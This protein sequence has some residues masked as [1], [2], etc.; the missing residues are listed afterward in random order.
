[1]DGGSAVIRQRFGDGDQAIF[2]F[3]GAAEAI[4]DKFPDDAVK[5]DLPNSHRFGQKIADLADPLGI[6][7][8][9]LVGQGPKKS[10]GLDAPEGRH[11]IFLFDDNNADKVLDAYGEML[12]DTFSERELREG[13]FTAVGQVH[14]PPS[15]EGQPKFPHHMGHYWPNYDPELARRDAAPRVFVQYVLAGQ[16]T[17]ETT[18]EA[19]PAVERIA[20]GVLRLAGMAKGGKSFHHHR[21]IHLHVMNLLHEWAAVRGRYEE[22]IVTYAVKRDVP[23][24]ETWQHYW[25]DVVRTVAET[26]A[27]SSLSGPEVDEFLAWKNRSDDEPALHI[28][29]QRRDNVFRYPN[30][31]PKVHIRIGSIHSIKGETHT[32]TLVCETF[33]NKHNLDKLRPW[34]TGDRKGWKTSDGLQQ[35]Y[36]LKVHY[37]A[38]TRPTH[39]LCLAMKRTTFE[40][41]Q[42]NLDQDV[43]DALGQRGWQVKLVC[44]TEPAVSRHSG[45]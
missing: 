3:W 8:Y 27:G 21:H 45:T 43:V 40:T 37:V 6:D 11:T 44:Q 17:A 19:Y 16:G 23:T 41:E 38:V 2:D 14:K 42:G 33:W 25:R 20:E 10:R 24:K 26:I 18:G 12:L 28:G 39:L 15:D 5:K 31:D 9:G 13:T 4:T 29:S 34:I 22:L 32:A 1:L 30:D 35:R 7:P 36:R